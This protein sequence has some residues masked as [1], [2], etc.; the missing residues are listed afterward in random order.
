MILALKTDTATAELQILTIDGKLIATKI[1]EAGRQL[2]QQL[3]PE[4]ELLLD[5]QKLKLTDVS[6]IVVYRG[7]GSFTGLRIGITVA[8]TLAYS[9]NI[10]ITGG[11]GEAW[12]KDGLDAL[13][14]A[15]AAG[16]VTPEYGGEANVTKPRK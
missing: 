14:S 7:P 13:E 4:I 12:L 8:N 9:L 1:W 10:P 15:L 5:S 16:I 3:M 11:A 6:G 2:S